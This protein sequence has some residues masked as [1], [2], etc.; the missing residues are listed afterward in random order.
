MPL[1]PLLVGLIIFG[2]LLYIVQRLPIEPWVKQAIY[3]LVVLF[4]LLWLLGFLG[5]NPVIPIHR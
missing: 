3:V 1:I 4:L 2:L 5:F